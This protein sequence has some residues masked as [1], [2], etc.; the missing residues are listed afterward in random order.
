M[1]VAELIEVL[2][3]EPIDSQVYFIITNSEGTTEKLADIDIIH[4]EDNTTAFYLYR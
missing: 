4:F 3:S 1:T 2:Q